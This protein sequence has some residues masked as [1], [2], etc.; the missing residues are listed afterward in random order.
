MQR[1]EAVS[2]QLHV[3]AVL[4][5]MH[6]KDFLPAVS[7]DR[8][9]QLE[10]RLIGEVTVPSPNSLLEA[11]WSLAVAL[12]H[13]STVVGFNHE[14]FGLPN[15]FPDQ[16]RDVAEVGHP[17][18]AAGRIEQILLA[19][20]EVESD[21]I[22]GVVRDAE[23]MHFEGRES[24]GLSCFEDFPVRTTRQFRLYCLNGIAIG[25]NGEPGELGETPNARRMI[26]V[27]VGQENRIQFF[28]FNTFLL[29]EEMKLLAGKSCIYKDG[30][31]GDPQK[32]GVTG[33][34][35]AQNLKVHFHLNT[36]KGQP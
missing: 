13:L 12:K 4:A 7:I 21:R 9:K 3:V 29:E 23:W 2:Y 19:P 22:V 1:T 15:P 8:I 26:V 28:Q 16:R 24:E 20:L 27:L 5:Q 31:V 10:S 35:G 33:A 6:E 36:D 32:S 11:P 17:S 34:T 18:Q 25:E 14:N 30:R